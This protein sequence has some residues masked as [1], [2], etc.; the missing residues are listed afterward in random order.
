VLSSF[1]SVFKE[2]LGATQADTFGSRQCLIGSVVLTKLA[3][4]Y[5]EG[6]YLHR[7]NECMLMAFELFAVPEKLSLPPHSLP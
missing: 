4:L 1:R 6:R 7:F 3:K 5:Y 2:N